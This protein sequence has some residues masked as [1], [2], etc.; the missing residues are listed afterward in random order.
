MA[1]MIPPFPKEQAMRPEPP[2]PVK[3]IQVKCVY[4]KESGKQYTSGSAT[5]LRSDF[6]PLFIYPKDYG[7]YLNAVGKLPGLTNGKWDGPFTVKVGDCTDLIIPE[8]N[9]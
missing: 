2:T 7:V 9:Q 4:F 1:R 3:T 5:F 8:L 6:G